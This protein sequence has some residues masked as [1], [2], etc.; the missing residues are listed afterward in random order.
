MK[1]EQVSWLLSNIEILKEGRWPDSI[2]GSVT[3]RQRSSGWAFF[4]TPAGLAATLEMRLEKC[5]R[6]GCLTKLVLCHGEGEYAISSMW[7][8]PVDEM[9]RRINS[10]VN[11][12]SGKKPK[13]TPYRF[14]IMHRKAELLNPV[15]VP[16]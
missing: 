15:L 3:L 14:Y 4:E 11:Y 10:V 7:G 13:E 12:C 8:I 16:T 6:D 2:F 9:R 5:G 1:P